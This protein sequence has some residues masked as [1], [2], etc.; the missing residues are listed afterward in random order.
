ALMGG[1]ITEFRQRRMFSSGVGEVFML[2]AGQNELRA[3]HIVFAGLG[4]FD[5]FGLE[6]LES[7]AENVARTLARTCVREFVTVPMGT[8]TGIGLE[9]ALH[10][11]LRGFFRG[12]DDADR[13][14]DFRAVT[15]C[16]VDEARYEALR[17]ALYRLSSSALCE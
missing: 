17:W 11:L 13:S 7:A 9:Q 3:D 16:E 6:V 15:F 1:A 12:L 2:P 4:R 14:H 10:A 8:G 5:R